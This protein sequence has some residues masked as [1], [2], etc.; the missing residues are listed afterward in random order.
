MMAMDQ[1]YE[2]LSR[3]KPSGLVEIPVSWA[4]DD[5]AYYGLRT[6]GAMPDPARV[7]AIF[8]SEFDE[9]YKEGTLVVVTMHPAISGLRSRAVVLTKLID[10][11]T[12]RRGVWF[13]TCGDI[14]T[15]VKARQSSSR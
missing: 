3:G 1:P 8:E 12:A 7:L 6:D 4:L 10:H 15:F 14:A 5:F 11:M 2:L 9:A 13:A